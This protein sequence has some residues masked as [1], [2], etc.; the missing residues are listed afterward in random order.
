MRRICI[1]LTNLGKYVEGCLVGQWLQLPV[2]E[3]KLNEVLQ[4]IGINKQ[5]EEYFITD[6]E[7]EIPNLEINQ[8]ASL[9]DLNELAAK[10]EELTDYD[11]EKLSAILEWEAHTSVVDIIEII[12]NL[13]SYDLLTEVDSDEALGEYFAIECQMF[14]AVPENLLY[15]I[16]YEKYGR[17][18]RLSLDC[19]YTSFGAII[20]N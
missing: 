15:Y 11:C 6:S 3:D 18:L 20:R 7:T 4:Q 10:I 2:P 8:H 9:S 12:D 5:Y 14:S 1:Y 17:D 13:N 16:D 19:C